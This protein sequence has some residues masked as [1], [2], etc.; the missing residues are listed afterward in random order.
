MQNVRVRTRTGSSRD[1]CRFQRRC[2]F[3]RWHGTHL[4]LAIA[5]ARVREGVAQPPDRK[6]VKSDAGVGLMGAKS[7]VDQV[8]CGEDHERSS[9][10]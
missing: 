6:H 9:Q 10:R 5:V 1:P 2:S 8:G 3:G 4:H 7:Q